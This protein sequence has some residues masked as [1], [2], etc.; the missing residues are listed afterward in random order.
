MTPIR[1]LAATHE[2]VT[3]AATGQQLYE[4]FQAEPNLMA[5]AVVDAKRRPI[6]LV[7]RHSFFLKLAAHYGRALYAGRS[8]SHL[9][10]PEPILVEGGQEVSTFIV[11]TLL[12]R[13][14]E[15]QQGF[16]VVEDGRY[17]GVGTAMDLLRAISAEN[18]RRA[19]EQAAFNQTLART[20]AEAAEAH[21][22]LRQAVDAMPE[23]LAFFDAEDRLVLWNRR[24][25]DLHPAMAHALAPGL[26][27]IDLL[28]F[29][30]AAGEYAETVGREQAW[31][32]ERLARRATRRGLARAG[33]VP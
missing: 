30:L 5:V 28:K 10:D 24:Y 25:A 26:P 8:I 7:E 20:H 4:L 23:G 19:E 32:E 22:R 3:A 1:D 29:G 21:A 11:D 14:S 18:A 12:Q 31:I 15:L 6:G 27:F 16:V 13:P 2:P 17:H 33:A 9:M